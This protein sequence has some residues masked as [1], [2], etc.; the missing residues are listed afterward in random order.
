MLDERRAFGREGDGDRVEP[1]PLDVRI[2]CEAFSPN[3]RA[4]GSQARTLSTIDAVECTL[5]GPWSSRS[6]FDHGDDDTIANEQIDLGATDTHV[7]TEDV[8]TPMREVRGRGVFG[9]R[10]HGTTRIRACTN[11]RLGEAFSAGRS[12]PRR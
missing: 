1:H 10:T 2:S 8:A 3:A 9:A 4:C 12:S 7:A 5:V 11:A 6:H